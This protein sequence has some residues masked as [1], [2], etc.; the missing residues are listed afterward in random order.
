MQYRLSSIIIKNHEEYEV[1]KVLDSRQWWSKLE[2]LVHWRGYDID[3]RTW[4]PIQNL[5]NARCREVTWILN[6]R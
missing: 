5:I 4:E 6:E 1:E 3:E 2:Y